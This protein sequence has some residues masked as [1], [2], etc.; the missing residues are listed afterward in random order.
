MI[1]GCGV[2]VRVHHWGADVTGA[3]DVSHYVENPCCAA[4]VGKQVI[5]YNLPC[6]FCRERRVTGYSVSAEATVA[7]DGLVDPRVV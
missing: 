2:T 7:A 5:G 3:A 1:A 6:C 4:L